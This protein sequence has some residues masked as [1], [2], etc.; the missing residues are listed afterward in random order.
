MKIATWNINSVRQRL[1]LLQDF[2]VKENPDIL[3]LQELKCESEQWVLIESETPYNYYVHGQKSYN[4]VAI[5]SKFKANE[6]VTNFPANPCFE[7]S[8]FIE[9]TCNTDI[10]FCR[11]ISLYAPNGGE[12]D[13]DKFKTK[14]QFYDALINY[15][16]IIRAYDESL[17][18]GGDFN[19]APFDIDIHSSFKSSNTTCCT[20]EEKYKMRSILNMGFYD[21][22]RLANPNTQ[23]FSWWDYRA[24]AFEQNKGMRIDMLIASGRAAGYFQNSYIDYNMRAQHKPSDHAPVVAW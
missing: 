24:G 14:L 9:I 15:L 17:I 6:I 11:F 1:S 10:G 2:L 7:Q 4:G 3:F 23:E 8:R 13:S 19:I 20:V 5:L 21:L 18:I 22:Y 16:E 12:V